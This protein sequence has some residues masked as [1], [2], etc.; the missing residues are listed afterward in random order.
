VDLS[1]V[2]SLLSLVVVEQDMMLLVEVVQEVL[3][4]TQDS[5]LLMEHIL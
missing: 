5:P 4:I 2:V 1:P 3:F